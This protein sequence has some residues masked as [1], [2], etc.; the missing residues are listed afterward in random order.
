MLYI[1]KKA[2]YFSS[3]FFSIAYGHG[4]GPHTFIQLADGWQDWVGVAN[5]DGSKNHAKTNADTNVTKRK[6]ND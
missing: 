4:F 6:L 1:L 3:I 2:I 5:L